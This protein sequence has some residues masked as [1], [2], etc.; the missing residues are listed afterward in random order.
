MS[1]ACSE[2][3]FT[4][5]DMALIVG[6]EDGDPDVS[7][8]TGKTAILDAILWVIYGKCR[9]SSV[10]KVIKRDRT[11][12][13]VT[14]IFDLGNDRYK[15]VRK[16]SKRTASS[17]VEF[18]RRDADTWHSISHD[19]STAITKEIARK[20][21]MNHDTFV[22]AVY[23]KQFDISRFTSATPSQR[24]NILKEIL[25]ISDWDIYQKKAKERVV[26]LSAQIEALDDRIKS[27]GDLNAMIQNNQ[28]AR[29]RAR[30]LLEEAQNEVIDYEKKLDKAKKRKI[31]A[32]SSETIAVIEKL[33]SIDSREKEIS[34]RLIYLRNT[35]KS[36]NIAL[37]NSDI[38]VHKVEDRIVELASKIL[39]IS[40]HQVRSKAEKIFRD[41][42][43]STDK[44]EVDLLQLE[45]DK[46][47]VADYY[48]QIS[49]IKLYLKQM[50]SLEPGKLCPC[51][52]SEICDMDAVVKRRK[53]RFASLEASLSENLSRLNDLS[54]VVDYQKTVIMEA[55]TA[56]LEISRAELTIS[57]LMGQIESA[58]RSNEAAQKE[59]D[60][61]KIEWDTLKEERDLLTS[62]L[63]AV[64][65]LEKARRE[66]DRLSSYFTS[67]RSKVLSASIE[68]G[69]LQGHAEGLKR[70]ISEKR[71]LVSKRPA[72]LQQLDIYKRLQKA[73]GK[74]GVPAIIMENVADDLKEYT[75]NTLRDIC[76][77][78][79]SVDFITQNRTDKGSWSETFEFAISGGDRVNDDFKDLSGGE[80]VD[81]S[82]AFRLALSEIRVRRAGS[83]IG[84]LLLDEVDQALDKRGVGSLAETIR[85]LSK[86]FKILVI[87]HNDLMKD[88]FDHVIT[89]TKGL[90][91]SVIR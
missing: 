14:F 75:N 9:F 59:R 56:A 85:V 33:Q 5:F 65:D 74:S 53:E 48:K 83:D 79:M 37:S 70:R 26:K 28:E 76:S 89:V 90:S 71:T 47:S 52:L 18:L 16:M 30:L 35:V 23:F 3:D 11:M 31:K 50:R 42:G 81:I 66:V 17:E 51:C 34:D 44:I 68:Y 78:P 61:L 41:M 7:N 22:N 87:T 15:I 77:E 84:F 91:G 67:A 69:N 12:C 64:E 88:K 19:T 63:G 86:K 4:Q 13:S 62:S 21:G 82:I 1:H 43:R 6:E 57:K 24:K 10:K 80:Q 58:H 46:K 27:L 72:I 55:N 38:E 49:S 29:E 8:G 45:K 39:K 32:E 60:R 73:F 36:N 25:Q 54:P 40:E 2:I 20:I